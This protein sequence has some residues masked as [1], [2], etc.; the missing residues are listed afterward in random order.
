MKNTP[1][2]YTKGRF[3]VTAPWSFSPTVIYECIAIRSF[4]DVYKQLIDVYE[5]FY[6]PMGLIDGVNGFIF[7]DEKAKAPNIIT[8]VGSDGTVNYVPD[9][10]IQAFPVMADTPYHHVALTV[11]L[12]ALPEYVEVDLVA[13]E[14]SDLVSAKIGT[15]ATASI[16]VAPLSSQPTREQHETIETARL[17]AIKTFEN[18]VTQIA[19][20]QAE[21]ALLKSK[22]DAATQVL[23]NHNLVRIT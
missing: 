1:P 11:S 20:L 6:K 8:L 13:R 23:L 4:E 12:G 2:M 22:L 10:Y 17:N 7:S 14:V 21:N 5:A 18:N 19:K 15:N 16:G 9:T 3:V